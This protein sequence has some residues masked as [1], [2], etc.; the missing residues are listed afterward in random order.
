VLGPLAPARAEPA[1]VVL[2]FGPETLQDLGRRPGPALGLLSASQGGY[3]PEQTLLDVSQGARVPLPVYNPERPPPLALANGRIRGWAAVVRRAHDAS[4]GLVPGLLGS[5]SP[6]APSTPGAALAGG[7]VAA[8]AGSLVNDAG[9]VLLVYGVAVLAA[10]T[11]YAR[12]NGGER[13]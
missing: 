5:P 7:L 8:V 1:R 11:A 12:G 9:P 2:A 10:A 4:G 3:A 6:A 13:R